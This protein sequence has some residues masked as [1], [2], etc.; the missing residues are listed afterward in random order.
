MGEPP[1]YSRVP[2]ARLEESPGQ[3]VTGNIQETRGG[4]ARE[5]THSKTDGEGTGLW[6][7]LIAKGTG[8][9]GGGHSGS[10]SSCSFRLHL[11]RVSS[12]YGYLCS[13]MLSWL[14][15]QL[16]QSLWAWLVSLG[17]HVWW[18]Y[19]NSCLTDEETRTLRGSVLPKSGMAS[20]VWSRV[21]IFSL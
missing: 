16:I 2:R 14:E 13:H 1:K 7:C 19:N 8:E 18:L 4:Q 17:N 3:M 5:W 10:I 6:W 15:I 11:W 21:H 20:E 12:H 9:E